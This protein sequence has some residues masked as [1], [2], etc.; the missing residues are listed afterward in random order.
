MRPPL[1]IR[2]DRVIATRDWLVFG[3][4]MLVLITTLVGAG[5]FTA[6][7]IIAAAWIYFFIVKANIQGQKKDWE[8]AESNE[9]KQW[10]YTGRTSVSVEINTWLLVGILIMLGVIADRLG[11]AF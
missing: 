10:M 2:R 5:W 8:R 6:I 11:G 3:T 1:D 4:V 7:A 9:E